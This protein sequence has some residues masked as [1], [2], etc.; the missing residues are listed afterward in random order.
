MHKFY[1]LEYTKHSRETKKSE[2]VVFIVLPVVPE[3]P[4]RVDAL[5][6]VILNRL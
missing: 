3:K 4:L 6:V 1:I 2:E 5:Q